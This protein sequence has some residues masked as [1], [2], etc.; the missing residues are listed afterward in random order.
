MSVKLSNYSRPAP[1]QKTY[2]FEQVIEGPANALYESN[3]KN[4]TSWYYLSCFTS[5]VCIH[6]QTGMVSIVDAEMAQHVTFFRSENGITLTI[7]P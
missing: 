4:W 7:T 5:I 6:K 2:S 1:V 3:N